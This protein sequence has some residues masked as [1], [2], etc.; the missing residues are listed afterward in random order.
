MDVNIVGGGIGVNG[1]VCQQVVCAG[2]LSI[3]FVRRLGIGGQ[4]ETIQRQR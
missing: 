1:M 2:D 4:N 3:M